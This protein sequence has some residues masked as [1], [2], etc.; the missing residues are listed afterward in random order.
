[1]RRIASVFALLLLCAGAPALAQSRVDYQPEGVG[2]RVEFP[3]KPEVTSEDI[4]TDIGKVR[5]TFAIVATPSRVYM[6]SHNDYPDW[7]L[8]KYGPEKLLNDA[9]R[10]G[11]IGTNK[12][13]SE[14]RITIGNHP[15]RHWTFDDGTG[16]VLV[17]RAAIVGTRLYQLVYVGPRNSEYGDDAKRFIASFELIAR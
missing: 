7:V 13:R 8:K 4:E 9:T 1:M 16:R 6:T 5:A 3:G 17:M 12:L 11:K 14:E 15:A 2:Y 10:N